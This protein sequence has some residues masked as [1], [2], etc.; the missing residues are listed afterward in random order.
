MGKAREAFEK[1]LGGMAR[2]KGRRVEERVRNKF[3]QVC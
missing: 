3:G 1:G 2:K